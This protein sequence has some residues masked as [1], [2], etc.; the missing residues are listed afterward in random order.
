MEQNDHNTSEAPLKNL[1]SAQDLRGS[2]SGMGPDGKGKKRKLGLP[3]LAAVVVLGLAVGAYFASE[4]FKPAEDTTEDTTTTYTSR[5]DSTQTSIS[6]QTKTVE[7]Y[8]GK[9]K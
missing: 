2:K 5:N 1:A 7:D 6:I 4:H 8:Q 9:K 3:I